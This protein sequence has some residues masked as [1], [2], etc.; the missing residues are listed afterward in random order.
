MHAEQAISSAL[1]KRPTF[2]FRMFALFVRFM[3]QLF[4]SISG[5]KT[6][7]RYWPRRPAI[8]FQMVCATMHC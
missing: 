8:T 5:V 1:S 6:N 3:L 7:V 2:R 4:L